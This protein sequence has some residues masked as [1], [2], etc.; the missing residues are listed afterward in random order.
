MRVEENDTL[1]NRSRAENE[2]I[3]HV[4]RDDRARDV[5][6]FSGRKKVVASV[7]ISLCF[8]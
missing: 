1:E 3:V 2:S 7:P 4:R 5:V 6:S 8:A